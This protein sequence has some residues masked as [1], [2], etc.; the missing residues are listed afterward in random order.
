MKVALRSW[1]GDT[2]DHNFCQRENG[3]LWNTM[4]CASPV[5]T[6]QPANQPVTRM[7]YSH[8]DSLL[9]TRTVYSH[10]DSL[11]V[12]RTGYLSRGPSS[13]HADSLQSR[14]QSTSHAERLPVTRTGYQ[15]R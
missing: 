12:T 10:A 13:S 8:A 15:S 7:V 3:Q 2:G 4:S 1:K 14:G 5:I 9:V 11:L 6:L